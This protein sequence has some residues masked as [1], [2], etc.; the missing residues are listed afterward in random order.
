[1]NSLWESV[2]Q[3]SRRDFFR[4]SGVGFAAGLAISCKS[5][6]VEKALPYLNGQEGLTPGVAQW[7]ATTCQGLFRELRRAGPQPGWATRVK[8]E[9]NPDHPMN[10]GGLCAI[11]QAQ[12]RGLYDPARLKQPRAAGQDCDW[13]SSTP[14]FL[15]VLRSQGQGRQD[16][17][18]ER[19]TDQSHAE[20]C[21]Q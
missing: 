7:Y 5:K 16:P 11:G 9:G 6:T 15:H 18:P 10:R 12:T 8:L 14:N 4:F 21:H 19:N 20:D 3:I 13:K 17:R 1:M 2:R